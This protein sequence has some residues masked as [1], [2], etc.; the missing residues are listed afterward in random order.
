[1]SIKAMHRILDIIDISFDSEKEVDFFNDTTLQHYKILDRRIYLILENLLA[2][3]M[4]KGIRLE[5]DYS[6]F[7]IIQEIPRLTFKGMTYLYSTTA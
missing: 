5:G 7:K 1:M 4:I 6:N 3:G 2:E